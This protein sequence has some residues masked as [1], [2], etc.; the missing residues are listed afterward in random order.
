MS[1]V[2]KS[3]LNRPYLRFVAAVVLVVMA[4]LLRQTTVHYLG[5]ELPPFILFYP[6]VMIVAVLGG[7]WP[8]LL[9]TALSALLADY[10]IVPPHGS[11]AIAT[12]SDAVALALFLGMGLF[13]SLVAEGYRRKSEKL[14]VYEQ[15]LVLR[16][17]QAKLRQS[18]E[19]FETLANAIPQLCWMANA[20]GWIF[21][22][23]QRWYEYTGNLLAKLEG[24]GWQS[25]LDPDS[26]PKVLEQWKA[27]IATGQPF[28]MV[29][30]LRGGDGVFRPFLTRVMP[31]KDGSGN[32]VRWFGTNTD[33]S[34]L[35][36]TDEALR[37][38][39]EKFSALFHASSIAMSLAS[40]PDG[41]MEEVNSAWLEVTGF[42]RKEEVLGKTSVELGVIADAVARE[43]IVNEFRQHHEV[44]NAE[45]A[46]ITNTGSHRVIV[47]NLR[48][49]EIGGRSFLLSTNEDITS[50]KQAEAALRDSEEQFRALA[51]AIPQLCWMANADGWI[52]WYNQRWYE[53]TGTTPEQM[54][55]WGWQSVHD[56][57]TLPQVVDQW[58]TSL[59]TGNPFDMVFPLRGA[60]G[61]FRPF[62]TRI[63]PV[64][65]EEGKV[66]RWFGS[67]TDI[68]EL[69]RAEEAM[70]ESEQR[71]R[72]L[73]ESSLNGLAQCRLIYDHN[74]RPADFV[75]V[76]VNDAFEKLTG[77]HDVAGKSYYGLFPGARGSNPELL[78]VYA[79]VVSTGQP[80]RFEVYFEPLKIWFSVSAH[81]TQGQHFVV[82]FDNITERKRAEEALRASEERLRLFIEHAPAAL[83]MFDREM[84][85]L[86]VSRRW[87][88]DYGLGDRDV[89]GLSHYDLFP[90]VPE[91][92]KEVH[93][94]GLAG[95]VLRA[96]ADR[97]E[98][99]DGSVQW[100]RWEVRPWRD[101]RGE[102]AGIVIFAEEITERKRAQDDLRASEEKF[103][104][105]FNINPAAIIITRL[106]DGR[107]LE[108]NDAF[109][110]MFGY[111]RD[112][113]LGQ[114][115]IQIW[116]DLED[117]AR[118]VQKLQ[119]KG[120]LHNLE[121]TRLKKSGEPFEVLASA[122][123]L[124]F[125]GEQLI[126]STCLD[127][128]DRK[129][130]QEA[131][132][133]QQAG[134]SEQLRAL[135]ARL[136]QVREEE[137]TIVARDLHD[138]IGQ[139]LTAIKMDLA[140][141]ARR[142]PQPDGEVHD[143]VKSTIELIND[144]VR[145]VRKICSGLRPGVLDDLGLAAAIEWQ[146]NEFASRTGIS[147]HVSVPPADLQVDGER[148]TAIFRIFQE[149]FT[150][151]I[152]HAEAQSVWVS[153]CQQDG[154][155]VLTVED[156]G[157][158]FRLADVPDSLGLLG[159]KERAQACGGD[160]QVSSQPGKG[161]I[162]TVC[163]PLIACTEGKGPCTF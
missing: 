161:T 22:Y 4:L 40:L 52:F 9:A 140:W 70:S 51:N 121:G 151:V 128:S 8:G 32:V 127:I 37:Q 60:D 44:R 41:R 27:S 24:W 3:A 45:L 66:V 94:R 76:N 131:L 79:R 46:I 98:R 93:R 142:L 85:Y 68:S 63:M 148:A 61:V 25:L 157:R 59:A 124:A 33:I 126:L 31:V 90:E 104:R 107:I 13:M 91:R 129:R 55:G 145:A 43:R 163:I 96:E 87:L 134:E 50:R 146:A 139:I 72:M 130:A 6:A 154:D 103:A 123:V 147:C 17:S 28:E 156:D 16:D 71:Y 88:A 132:L 144:G 137:R 23:N 141:V 5:A 20:D 29:F 150:N 138:Q 78:D 159:M 58:N 81:R 53:Y 74:G 84:R 86:Q 11:F 106:H 36:R 115:A 102:V 122:V 155:L 119:E 15:E 110:K 158:G 101:T 162:V 21:W 160:A 47:A 18:E 125:G 49:V 10:W 26:S 120:S 35:R 57:E 97:F 56:P 109:V 100:I 48:N 136:Q 80:A 39:E 114:F 143:R 92:W 82:V 14:A 19:K 112:E 1:E 83:A 117:R 34:E 149:S 38:S 116:P 105:A 7:L 77:L 62:L 95:E 75:Y 152:R 67:N 89:R 64:K 135:T 42:T 54:K 65:D 133:R 108:V 2:D 113:I 30:P 118:F 111:G 73:F 69:R 99:T 153:L 12:T